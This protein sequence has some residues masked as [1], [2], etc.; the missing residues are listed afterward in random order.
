MCIAGVK[1][2]DNL[3]VVLIVASLRRMAPDGMNPLY[4]ENWTLDDVDFAIYLGCGKDRR[5]ARSR[6]AYR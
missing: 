6:C 2:S 3:I 4:T 1:V 5:M